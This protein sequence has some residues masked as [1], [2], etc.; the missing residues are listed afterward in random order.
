VDVF[1]F[2]TVWGGQQRIAFAT[3]SP[4]PPQQHV[5]RTI[6]PTTPE[7]WSPMT[8]GRSPL[9]HMQNTL[10]SFVL[11]GPDPQEVDS[12][13]DPTTVSIVPIPDDTTDIRPVHRQ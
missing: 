6:T 2:M 8:G 10:R 12:I 7:G 13:G 3:V 4:E 9:L 11:S 5:E 1:V